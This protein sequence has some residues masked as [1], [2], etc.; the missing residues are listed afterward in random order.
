VKV[1]EEWAGVTAAIKAGPPYLVQQTNDEPYLRTVADAI[2]G[3]PSPE[4]RAAL[5]VAEG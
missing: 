5:D 2:Y 4:V 1:A 3:S